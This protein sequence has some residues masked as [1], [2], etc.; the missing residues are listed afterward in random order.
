MIPEAELHSAGQTGRLPLRE[1]RSR[2]VIQAKA[3]RREKIYA[4]AGDTGVVPG[5]GR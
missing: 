5:C 2:A 4:V 1:A 3:T